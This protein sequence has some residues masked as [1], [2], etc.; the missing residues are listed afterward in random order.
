MTVGTQPTYDEAK[1]E[2]EK[3]WEWLG[4]Q[5]TPA[6]RTE[7]HHD[8]AWT[9]WKY[10]MREAGCKLPSQTTTGVSRCFCGAEITAESVPGH[11]DA[12]HMG[13]P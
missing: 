10:A 4:P 13:K 6:M 2:F 7:W 8:R 1:A 5:I 12:E 3:A 9:A 11:V